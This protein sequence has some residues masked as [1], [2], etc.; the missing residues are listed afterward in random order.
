MGY[1]DLLKKTI[2]TTD[3][4]P[5]GLSAV[6]TQY[7]REKMNSEEL[8]MCISKALTEIEKRYSQIE[9]ES[10][11]VVW[12]VERLNIYLLGNSFELR[13]DNKALE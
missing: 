8:I 1:F 10:L 2:L 3:A 9:K 11:A 6:L 12:A 13:V 5:V 4:S 7:H